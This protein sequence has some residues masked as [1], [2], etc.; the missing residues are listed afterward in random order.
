MLVGHGT[1]E[2]NCVGEFERMLVH[3]QTRIVLGGIWHKLNDRDCM[4]ILYPRVEGLK[5]QKRCEICSKLTIKTP[6]RYLFF[7][8]SN[9]SSLFQHCVKS[10][11]IQS[12]FPVWI[13]KNTD[14]QKLSIWTLLTQCKLSKNLQGFH[15]R[16]LLLY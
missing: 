14:Q 7:S 1:G 8:T 6:E 16:C 3:Y 11:Q 12:F 9:G 4:L 15:T 10:V 5:H 13:L 2:N